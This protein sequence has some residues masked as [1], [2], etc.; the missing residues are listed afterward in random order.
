MS[1]NCPLSLYQGMTHWGTPIPRKN[2]NPDAV[3]KRFANLD[4]AFYVARSFHEGERWLMQCF[5]DLWVIHKARMEKVEEG[6]VLI[7]EFSGHRRFSNVGDLTK[8]HIY[9]NDPDE[10]FSE[11]QID[12]TM[13][14]ASETI[15]MSITVPSKIVRTEHSGCSAYTTFDQK[16]TGL[17]S[18]RIL[19][20]TCEDFMR[21][22]W[23]GP[24][25][26]FLEFNRYMDHLRP[27]QKFNWFKQGYIGT[28]RMEGN[29]CRQTRYVLHRHWLTTDFV[30]AHTQFY[31]LNGDTSI[32][33]Y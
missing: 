28:L 9:Q 32:H 4:I 18:G 31:Y 1:T 20:E 13:N 16:F 30:E 27:E 15:L 19:K 10:Q 11:V 12:F 29:N 7:S 8:L 6:S 33:T 17:P 2:D 26:A 3:M 24:E 21:M 25:Q 22:L 14:G 5:N 23:L